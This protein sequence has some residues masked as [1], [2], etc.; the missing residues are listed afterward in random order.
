MLRFDNS[1]RARGVPRDVDVEGGGDVRGGRGRRGA[2]PEAR[3]AADDELRF[4]GLDT[5]RP[6]LRLPSGVVLEGRY[7]MSVG[8]LLVVKPDGAEGAELL[9]KSETRLIFAP[10]DKRPGRRDATR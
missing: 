8:H 2:P 10:S 6:T 7:E 4:T 3:V 9:D 5:T 1:A